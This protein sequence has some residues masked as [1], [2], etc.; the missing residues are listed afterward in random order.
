M[1]ASEAMKPAIVSATQHRV[2]YK[3]ITDIVLDLGA[4]AAG[5]KSQSI[6]ANDPIGDVEHANNDSYICQVTDAVFGIVTAVDTFCLEQPSDGTMT[7]FDLIAADDTGFLGND[8]GSI[9]A[10][11]NHA[12]IG[13]AKGNNENAPYDNQEMKNKY[14]YITAGQASTAKGTATVT[15]TDTNLNNIQNLVTA[16]KLRANDAATGTEVWWT[17]NTTADYNTSY[18]AGK[19]NTGGT[20]DSAVKLAQ[21]LAIAIDGHG[22]FTATP[23]NGSSATITI[24][25]QGSLTKYGNQT[26]TWQDADGKT[27]GVTLSNFTGALPSA[28]TSGKF[29]IR[30]TGFMVPEDL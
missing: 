1:G 6:G 3:V 27:A 21:S 16:F 13:S 4:S 23:T 25:H 7:D 10:I 24:G 20:V 18:N 22:S 12:D 17:A 15:V 19:F 2:G 30:F 28:M 5:L 14:I 11:T 29:L 9:V 8:P 26:N